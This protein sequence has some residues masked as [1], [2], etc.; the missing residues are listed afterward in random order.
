MYKKLSAERKQQL[1]LAKIDY[2]TTSKVLKLSGEWTW[3]CFDEKLLTVKLSN[4]QQQSLIIDG[5]NIQGLDTT[6]IFFLHKLLAVLKQQG[7][8]I[9]KLD[10]HPDDQKLFSLSEKFSQVKPSNINLEHK[11]WVE[12]IYQVIANSAKTSY[13]LVTFFGQLCYTFI[14]L[15][16]RNNSI[17]MQGVLE[18][19][20]RAG[21]GG[22]LIC[23]MLSFLLGVNLTY[24]MAPQFVTYGAN[25]Y[26]VNFLGIA[27]LREVT[28]LIT[29]IIVAGR[30]GSAIAAS[31]GTMK[32]QEE[33]DAL[34]TMGIS[35]MRRLVAPQVIGLVIALP[36][37]TMLADVASMLGG[38]LFAKPLLSVDWHL[39]L[40]RL[41]TYVSINNFW[42]GII[43]SF[44]FAWVI[45]MV[46]SFC[47]FK[48]K[49]NA[50]SIG[51]QTTRSVVI[52][53]C[54]IVVVDALFAILFKALG[55]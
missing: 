30:T 8:Q 14:S 44:F 22:I 23:A 29:A 26:V 35:P 24:Q 2:N 54:L 45:G 48:V 46:G 41:Q 9:A 34:Q 19:I 12:E 13:Q 5:T 1:N 52:S 17:Y 49:S 55:V 43:K 21:I 3:S 32:V 53:I 50:D 33:I 27:M 18:T 38:M 37:L 7:N 16:K 4:V 25:V 51:V 6:G 11:T 39:F 31:I 42:V 28:P 47:G 15:F 36:I 40:L 10:L 20:S